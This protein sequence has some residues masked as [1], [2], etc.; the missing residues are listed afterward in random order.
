MP[1]RMIRV[2]RTPV[3]IARR[4]FFVCICQLE[5]L[6]VKQEAVTKIKPN[7]KILNNI[8]KYKDKLKFLVLLL[9]F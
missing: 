3:G 8:K 9:P 7:A 5:K 4:C 2:H 1:N 6:Y